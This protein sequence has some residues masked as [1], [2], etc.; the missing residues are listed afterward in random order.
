MKLAKLMW[1]G[2]FCDLGQGG[3][4]LARSAQDTLL[5]KVLVFQPLSDLVT[6][7]DNHSIKT[8]LLEAA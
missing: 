5:W 1:L 6:A 4:A 3:D 8:A 7:G 2:T